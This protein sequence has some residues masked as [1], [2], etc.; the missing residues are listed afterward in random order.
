VNRAAALAIVLSVAVGARAAGQG[1]LTREQAVEDVR[2]VVRVLEETH[3]DPYAAFGGKVAFKLRAQDLLGA[4]PVDGLTR[5]ELYTLLVPFLGALGDGH[6]SLRSPAAADGR[7][8][9][10]LPLAFAVAADATFVAGAAPGHED[11]IGARLV[12]VEDLPLAE[13]ETRASRILP[14]ENAYGVARAATRAVASTRYL[15]QLL[16]RDLDTLRLRLQTPTGADVERPIP[17][18]AAGDADPVRPARS[19]PALG[20]DSAAIWWRYLDAE[21]VGYLRL[22]SVVGREAFEDARGREDLPRYVADYYRRYLHRAAPADIDAAVAGV[23]CFTQSVADLLTRMRTEGAA[24]LVVDLRRNGGGWSS[25]GL[26]LYLLVYGSGYVDHVFPETWV[27]V[28]S[29]QLLALNGWAEG[30]LQAKWGADFEIG[31]YRRS[32][33]GP[34]RADRSDAEYAAA[35]ERYGCGLA[36][37]YRRLEG[38]PLYTP[39]VVVLVDTGTFSAAFQLAYHLWHLGAVV[40]GV[41]PAQAGNA[42]TNVVPLELP[43]SHLQGSVARSVQIYFPGDT[44][45]G[46]TLRP[47]FPVTWDVHARYGFDEQSEV[48]YALDLIAAGRVRAPGER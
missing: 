37:W 35:L 28:A 12:A 13:F 3:P 41:P 29:P 15:H 39:A 4:V 45:R 26:P 43:N 14:A 33:S 36:D 23:P 47:D 17:L 27:D 6:T 7:P 22:G 20:G 44:A 16:G 40:L 21:R 48:R 10:H 5:D 24:Y 34:P 1:R 19:W 9:R 38:R 46:R 32:V 30:D 2:H 31:D 8:T 18:L 11:L 25:L 42:Y